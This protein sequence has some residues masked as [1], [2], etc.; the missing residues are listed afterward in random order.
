M[1]IPYDDQVW[2]SCHPIWVPTD[3]F[4]NYHHNEDLLLK[5]LTMLF[6]EC[7][8]DRIQAQLLVIAYYQ[9][10]NKNK[11]TQMRKMISSVEQVQPVLLYNGSF[12]EVMNEVDNTFKIQMK[13]CYVTFNSI[14]EPI[15]SRRQIMTLVTIYKNRLPQHYKLM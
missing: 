2:S 3:S 15:L 5:P 9:A 13:N 4:F 11:Q 7:F 6:D 14:T 1:F 8:G 10:K 12:K